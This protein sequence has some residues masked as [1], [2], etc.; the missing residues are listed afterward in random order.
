MRCLGWICAI[1]LAPAAAGADPATPDLAA[2]TDRIPIRAHTRA[3]TLRVPLMVV[4]NLIVTVPPGVAYWATPN[5]QKEDWAMHW[6][7]SSWKSKL[8]STDPIVFDTNRFEANAIRHPIV[9]AATYQIGRANGL[10]PL[11][12]TAMS[13]ATSIVWEYLVEYKEQ[14]SINDMISN[15]TAGF[16]IGEP[17]FQIGLLADDHPTAARRALAMVVSPFH[18]AQ[19]ET[20]LSALVDQPAEPNRLEAFVG[21]H[22]VKRTDGDAIVQLHVGLDLEV[23][24]DAAFGRAGEGGRWVGPGTWNRVAVGADLG[25][26]GERFAGATLRSSTTYF[27][28]LGRDLDARGLGRQTFIGVGAG[29]HVE[30]R[31]LVAEWDKFAA[32]ELVN[33]R[34]GAWWRTPIGDLDLEAGGGAEVAMVQAH[35]LAMIPLVDNS[36][37]VLSRGYY[38]ATGATMQ[39]RA[40]VRSGRWSAELETVAHQFWSFDEHSHGGTQDPRDLADARITNLATVGI[41]PFSPGFRVELYGQ[42]TLRRGTGDNLSRDTI[43]RDAGLA[44]R[45]AF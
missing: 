7:W 6:D 39:A 10:S 29:F 45:A 42:Y 13:L 31:H 21:T 8:T 16:L 43:E 25:G 37:I 28:R 11:A 9:G 33:P 36:S 12:S 34:V 24:R 35:A 32:F 22:V 44:V 3:R 41:A 40:R 26:P 5:D 1:L 30:D 20:G 27:G 23:F 2:S 19:K 4:E 14:P 17:L 38:Y 15:T 18:R